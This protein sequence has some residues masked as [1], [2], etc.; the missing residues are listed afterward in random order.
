[1]GRLPSRSGNPFER[2]SSRP[3]PRIENVSPKQYLF[4]E[5]SS[6]LR[7]NCFLRSR[8]CGFRAYRD[9]A[10]LYRRFDPASGQSLASLCRYRSLHFGDPARFNLRTDQRDSSVLAIDRLFVWFAW[11]FSAFLL[12]ETASRDRFLIFVASTDSRPTGGA[13]ARKL[14]ERN[15]RRE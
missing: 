15:P 10:F 13:Q 6:R 2:P 14:R 7:S 1:M 8:G 9:C 11:H 5:N 12:L 3:A 4:P